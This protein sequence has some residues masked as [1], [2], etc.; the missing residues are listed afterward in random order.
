MIVCED[1]KEGK[2]LCNQTCASCALA[3]RVDLRFEGTHGVPIIPSS[4]SP[5]QVAVVKTT[6]FWL[7]FIECA[8]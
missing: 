6:L 7:T 5:P 2:E 3:L 4:P 1:C 8:Y